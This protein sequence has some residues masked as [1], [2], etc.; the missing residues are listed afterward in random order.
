MSRYVLGS[1]PAADREAIIQA[2]DDALAVFDDLAVGRV[3]RAMNQLNRRSKP[4][5]GTGSLYKR[6]A[7]MLI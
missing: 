1:P 3:D 5:P 2:I 6:I 7:K 4:A